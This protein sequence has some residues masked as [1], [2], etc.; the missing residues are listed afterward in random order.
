M[1]GLGPVGL[2]LGLAALGPNMLRLAGRIADRVALNMCTP[3]QVPA[4]VA[5]VAA[6]AAAA[7]RSTPPITV[8]IHCCVGPDKHNMAFGRRFLSGYL[9]APGYREVV[10]DAGFA[11]VVQAA[12]AAPNARTIGGLVTDEMLVRVLGFG[13]AAE[14]RQRVRSFNGLGVEAAVVPSLAKDP[15]GRETLI[16]LATP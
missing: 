10:A 7:G 8:W 5:L 2:R 14:V 4:M 16:A 3:S 9:R 12:A 1:T 6:G 15:T 13:T 11:E